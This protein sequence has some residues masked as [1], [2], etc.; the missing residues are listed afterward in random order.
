MDRRLRSWMDRR[1][2]LWMDRR[3]GRG[4]IGSRDCGWMEEEVVDG[5]LALQLNLIITH[6]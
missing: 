1:L 3:G 2:R 6:Y 5:E 4:W